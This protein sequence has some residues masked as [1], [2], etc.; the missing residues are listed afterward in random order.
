LTPK[1]T[2]TP[3]IIIN[4]KEYIPIKNETTK[5]VVINDKTYIPV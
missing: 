3:V 4:N 1:T 5:P 2:S